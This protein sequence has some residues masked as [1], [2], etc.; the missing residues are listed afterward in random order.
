M[1]SAA[2]AC[3]ALAHSLPDPTDLCSEGWHHGG[4]T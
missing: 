2:Q 3:D 4:F 1:D